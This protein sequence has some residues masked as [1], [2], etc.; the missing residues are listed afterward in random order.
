MTDLT[1]PTTPTEF[2]SRPLRTTF[3]LDWEKTA[4]LVIL[5]LALVTR[6]SGLDDRVVSHDESLH[7]QYAYQYYRGDG[8]QHNPMMHGPMV[9]HSAATFYWLFGVSD[10]S[11]RIPVALIG[12]VLVMLPIFLRPAGPGGVII[13]Q[14][15]APGFPVYD[16]LL[17]LYS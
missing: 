9:F 15:L 14:H 17:T 12:V 7:T 13:Y 2:L 4:Y 8:Y 10:G 3:A 1:T 16:L 5:I 11:A 6:L